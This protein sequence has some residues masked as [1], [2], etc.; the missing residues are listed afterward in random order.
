MFCGAAELWAEKCAWAQKLSPGKPQ[1]R[2]VKRHSLCGMGDGVK[3]GAGDVAIPKLCTESIRVHESH[4]RI[5]SGVMLPPVSGTTTF[6]L[7]NLSLWVNAAARPAA[8]AG[9]T[10]NP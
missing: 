4:L 8:P 6:A 9:S 2:Q 3:E 5:C 1:W 7:R 10:T